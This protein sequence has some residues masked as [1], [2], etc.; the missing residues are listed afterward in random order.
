MRSDR[1]L[2]ERTV[3]F[4]GDPVPEIDSRKNSRFFRLC[5]HV[6]SDIELLGYSR[7]VILPV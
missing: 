1:N 6:Q 3:T 2:T 5:R 7:S 4:V